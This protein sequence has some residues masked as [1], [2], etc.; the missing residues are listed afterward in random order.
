MPLL[1]FDEQ[2]GELYVTSTEVCKVKRK[3]GVDT[4]FNLDN[5]MFAACIVR[6]WFSSG[7][8]GARTGSHIYTPCA[9]T[10]M[11]HCAYAT[12]TNRSCRSKDGQA[13]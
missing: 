13:S 11:R 1:N 6:M 10:E 9:S 2:K 4:L 3:Q 5:G 8:A 12:R 7:R